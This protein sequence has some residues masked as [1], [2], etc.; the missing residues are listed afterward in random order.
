M[1]EG[2]GRLRRPQRGRDQGGKSW[3]S[4]VSSRKEEALLRGWDH[5]NKGSVGFPKAKVDTVIGR[6]H[7]V[8]G[9]SS[10]EN[11]SPRS[12]VTP[13]GLK[14]MREARPMFLEVSL[15]QDVRHRSSASPGTEFS[16]QKQ[17]WTQALASLQGRALQW[18]HALLPG[19]V[20]G[21]S[22]QEGLTLMEN[23]QTQR[24]VTSLSRTCKHR[25][26]GGSRGPSQCEGKEAGT[27]GMPSVNQR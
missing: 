7:G 21:S 14:V 8:G 16:G 1:E 23:E 2:L 24:T 22:A 12:L 15:F 9:G 13:R 20:T 19:A 5:D 17:E 4:G 18:G 3:E 11:P 10:E 25:R 26:H 6:V 27:C